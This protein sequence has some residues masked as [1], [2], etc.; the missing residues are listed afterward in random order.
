M[1]SIKNGSL[2]PTLALSLGAQYSNPNPR[3]FPI[4]D[5]W[6]GSWDAS[7]VFSWKL[8][9]GVKWFEAQNAEK[10]AA[11][12]K[13]G[14]NAVKRQNL[15]AQEQTLALLELSALKLNVA[16]NRVTLAKK[17][18]KTTETAL[19]NGRATSL[20]VVDRQ[21]DLALSKAAQQK[22]ALEIVLL[23]EKERKLNGRFGFSD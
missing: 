16:A 19:E 4:K 2:L 10:Q 11:A 14:A 3:N 22:T 7:L 23:R 8:D 6:N 17:A 12:A 21:R 20:D 1:A 18:L 13:A 5:Q 15:L 9:S